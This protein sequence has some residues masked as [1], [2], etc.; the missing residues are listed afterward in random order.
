MLDQIEKGATERH[1]NLQAEKQDDQKVLEAQLGE[2]WQQT[3][4][5][6]QIHKLEKEQAARVWKEQ[7]KHKEQMDK[8]VNGV[9]TGTASWNWGFS[10]A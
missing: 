2:F 4:Q 1:D 10:I 8:A 5:T 3:N 6:Q 9:T 7:A